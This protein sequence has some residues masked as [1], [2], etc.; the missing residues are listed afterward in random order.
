[1]RTISTY[2]RPAAFT[3]VEL[4][5]VIG[6]I[7]LLVAILLP[8]MQ[9]VRMAALNISCQSNLRQIGLALIM[10]QADAKQLMYACNDASLGPQNYARYA[11]N[12]NPPAPPGPWYRLGVLVEGGYIRGGLTNPSAPGNVNPNG[13]RVLLCPIR[14]SLIPSAALNTWLTATTTS[15]IKTGYSMRIL[16]IPANKQVR[17]RLD[18]LSLITVPP[19]NTTPVVCKQR[20]SI[21][22]DYA[23]VV[24]KN[25]D[26]HADFAQNGKDGY[27]FLMTDGTVE[28]VAL[29][30][31][32]QGNP[33]VGVVGSPMVSPTAIVSLREFF[34]NSDRLMGIQE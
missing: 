17:N 30:S 16:E 4:L 7:A 10:Y 31:Y 23:G 34:A 8:A 28:H 19:Y 26:M 29:S 18:R 12:N 33:A 9:R 22:S 6:I 27:N 1:M 3:L 32:L 5:V 24:N 14:D 11:V 2:R 13:S 20:V 21:V 25:T 15:A